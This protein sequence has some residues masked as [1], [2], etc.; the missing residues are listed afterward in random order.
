[1]A[2]TYI[3]CRCINNLFSLEFNEDCRIYILSR[4]NMKYK[5][6]LTIDS[7]YV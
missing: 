5:K 6:Y 7:K 1:M 2:E 3:L 4:E